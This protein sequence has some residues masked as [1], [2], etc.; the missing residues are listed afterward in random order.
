[1]PYARTAAATLSEGTNS[2]HAAEAS[3]KP[4]L[5]IYICICLYLYL[6]L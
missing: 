5:Y 6:Y 4:M 2:I 1:M 3:G